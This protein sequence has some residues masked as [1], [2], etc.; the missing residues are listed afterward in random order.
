L[1][2][3]LTVSSLYL[4]KV[5]G[6]CPNLVVF[7]CASLCC[8]GG[9]AVAP[10]SIY[11]G[12]LRN[13]PR[14]FLAW[15]GFDWRVGPGG[16]ER[17]VVFEPLGAATGTLKN[18][19]R[20]IGAVGPKAYVLSRT[21]TLN[22]KVSALMVRWLHEIRDFYVATIKRS[23]PHW[24]DEPW[25]PLA[26]VAEQQ[27]SLFPGEHVNFELEWRCLGWVSAFLVGSR[28]FWLGLGVFSGVSAY[29]LGSRR[30]WLCLCF[31]DWVSV[32]LVGSRRFWSGVNVFGNSC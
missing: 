19:K 4:E 17:R 21:K 32:F 31:L 18:S 22:A 1:G 29:I 26:P 8:A 28:R 7:Q 10:I 9:G 20:T 3:A 27:F 15:F 13:S 16:D 25:N 12:V 30:F 2:L 23:N 5:P 11:K 24:F 14:L 6:G